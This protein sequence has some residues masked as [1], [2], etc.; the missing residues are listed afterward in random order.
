MKY[1]EYILYIQVFI[2]SII[3]KGTRQFQHEIALSQERQDLTGLT[4]RWKKAH[5]S[6][7]GTIGKSINNKGLQA[8]GTQQYKEFKNHKVEESPKTNLRGRLYIKSE[9][10]RKQK[11]VLRQAYRKTSIPQKGLHC[12]YKGAIVKTSVVFSTKL[13][14]PQHIGGHKYRSN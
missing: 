13:N 2:V 14:T 4:K 10:T 12:T 6:L 11:K 5:Q 1:D 3:E 7:P 9:K 8:K